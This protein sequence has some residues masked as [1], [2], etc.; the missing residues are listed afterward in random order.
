MFITAS[1]CPKG[2]LVLGGKASKN[3]L[4]D[5]SFIFPMTNVTI[6]GVFRTRAQK[7]YS[8][9]LKLRDGKFHSCAYFSHVVLVHKNSLPVW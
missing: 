9:V 3:K 2:I 7:E 5:T 8:K 6:V 1:R 4:K